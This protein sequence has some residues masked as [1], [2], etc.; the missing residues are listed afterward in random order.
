M[1]SAASSLLSRTSFIGFSDV[2]SSSTTDGGGFTGGDARVSTQLTSSPSLEGSV[3]DRTITAS[4]SR[5]YDDNISPTP[6]YTGG[7]A[8]FLVV[9]KRLGKK[10]AMTKHKAL[11]E[12]ARL[13]KSSGSELS[14]SV[15]E[16]LLP[17]WVHV[18][19]RLVL[20]EN[21]RRVREVLFSTT[22]PALFARDRKSMVRVLGPH[23]IGPWWLAM[24]DSQK[25]VANAA[26]RAFVTIFPKDLR[27]SDILIESAPVII[28][29]LHTNLRLAREEVALDMS[30]SARSS[31]DETEERLERICVCSLTALAAL[32]MALDQETLSRLAGTVST[33]EA[34]DPNPAHGGAPTAAPSLATLASGPNS[35]FV[36]GRSE[37]LTEVIKDEAMW[38]FL[39]DP[40]PF[41]RRAA[42]RLLAAV[43]GQAGSAMGHRGQADMVAQQI[44]KMLGERERG[45]FPAMWEGILVFLRHFPE[46]L[47]SA[48]DCKAQLFPRLLKLVRASFCGAAQ[49]SCPS[50]LPFVASVPPALSRAFSVDLLGSLWTGASADKHDGEEPYMVAIIE[51]ATYMLIRQPC[52]DAEEHLVANKKELE[53]S[54]GPLDGNNAGLVF[55]REILRALARVLAREARSGQ[56]QA[57]QALLTALVQFNNARMERGGRRHCLFLDFD[58]CFWRGVQVVALRVLGIDDQTSDASDYD[59]ALS[60]IPEA[61]PWQVESRSVWLS[62]LLVDCYE[63]GAS[64]GA[65]GQGRVETTLYFLFWQCVLQCQARDQYKAT[66][67]PYLSFMKPIVSL[68]PLERLFAVSPSPPYASSSSLVLYFLLP[69]LEKQMDL[70][71]VK[72]SKAVVKYLVAITTIVNSWLGEEGHWQELLGTLT[73]NVD[74]KRTGRL[75]FLSETFDSLSTTYELA[76]TSLIAHGCPENSLNLTLLV[77][78]ALVPYVREIIETDDVGKRN[79]ETVAFLASCLGVRRSGDYKAREGDKPQFDLTSEGI[80]SQLRQPQLDSS[81]IGRLVER[82]LARGSH[83][84]LEAFMLALDHHDAGRSILGAVREK[85][86]AILS[87]AFKN[88]GP[89]V[90]VRIAS[91]LSLAPREDAMEKE[92]DQD[93]GQNLHQLETYSFRRHVTKWLHSLLAQGRR[94]DHEQDWAEFFIRLA[95]ILASASLEPPSIFLPIL[96]LESGLADIYLWDSAA[97]EPVLRAHMWRYLQAVVHAL[98]EDRSLQ[99]AF[100]VKMFLARSGPLLHAI[101]SAGVVSGEN[102]TIRGPVPGRASFAASRYLSGAPVRTS[103]PSDA[104]FQLL[105]FKS[106]EDE[107][108]GDAFHS[109]SQVDIEIIQNLSRIVGKQ[110]EIIAISSSWTDAYLLSRLISVFEA[111]FTREKGTFTPVQVNERAFGRVVLPKEQTRSF[112]S[113]DDLKMGMEVW[114]RDRHMPASIADSAPDRAWMRGN[115][116][117]IHRDDIEKYFTVKKIDGGETQMEFERLRRAKPMDISGLVAGVCEGLPDLQFASA[118]SISASAMFQKTSKQLSDVCGL[119]MS[120]LTPYLECAATTCSKVVLAWSLGE[121]LRGLQAIISPLHSDAVLRSEVDVWMQKMQNKWFGIAESALEQAEKE[122]ATPESQW[123]VVTSSLYLLAGFPSLSMARASILWSALIRIGLVTHASHG[124]SKENLALSSGNGTKSRVSVIPVD[125]FEMVQVATLFWT[126]GLSKTCREQVA[127]RQALEEMWTNSTVGTCMSESPSAFLAAVDVGLQTVLETGGLDLLPATKA[128]LFRLALHGFTTTTKIKQ[129]TAQTTVMSALRY[130]ICIRCRLLAVMLI[131]FDNCDLEWTTQ[132]YEMKSSSGGLELNMTLWSTDVDTLLQILES[133]G[134]SISSSFH[135]GA[136]HL[137]RPYLR[138][139]TEMDDD[140]DDGD[141]STFADFLPLL[142]NERAKTVANDASERKDMLRD[143]RIVARRLMPRF[144]RML[145]LWVA[146]LDAELVHSQILEPH[147]TQRLACLLKWEGLLEMLGGD[148][149]EDGMPTESLN[150]YR[151]G[152]FQAIMAWLLFLEHVEAVALSPSLRDAYSTYVSL[153]DSLP[154]LLLACFRILGRRVGSSADLVS[155][156]YDLQDL[157]ATSHKLESGT[158]SSATNGH[159]IRRLVAYVVVRTIVTFPALV[160]K[161]WS[162]DS[163]RWLTSSVFKFV[164]EYASG[165]IVQREIDLIHA[166]SRGYECPWGGGEDEIAVRGSTITREV[167][168]HYLKDDCT[169][170]IL[171]RLPLAYPLRNVEVECTRS[172]GVSADKLNRWQLQI[173]TLLSMRDGSI[174]DAVALWVKNLQR[175][176]EGMGPCPICMSIIEARNLSLPERECRT[177]HNRFHNSCILKWFA[178]SGKNRCVLCQ[179]PTIG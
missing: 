93:E 63:R 137:L 135:M 143:V 27:R 33:E 103:M 119:L 166:K 7:D 164:E 154:V 156:R 179:Q 159:D 31:T 9:F 32:L 61:G 73:R 15:V 96:L 128:S 69:T 177:C 162:S 152:L 134:Y 55:V 83:V 8:D 82:T 147:P 109:E 115:I 18:Y 91:I 139:V 70:I 105:F 19:P 167:T 145:S 101:L 150:G 76:R 126:V 47:T 108:D 136:F 4:S 174:V 161:W 100:D 178:T 127:C 6:F 176:F 75:E 25:E 11:L 77:S 92:E 168:A 157:W 41:V 17:Y 46:T 98:E 38:K 160:R 129:S 22:L 123:A 106:W 23:L 44:C 3:V 122:R 48:L 24:R 13:I 64:P 132:I 12:L 1:D 50:L 10:D 5:V 39:Q 78:D 87:S 52:Q 16:G 20:L 81:A 54:I 88:I 30:D 65:T 89:S 149:G 29:Y 125:M 144:H 173:I 153:L 80:K 21:D 57:F 148:E 85:V 86:P 118:A 90:D 40:R 51:I 130:E 133:D 62:K 68:I 171:L 142:E 59:E 45:N 158:G 113:P 60:L 111:A 112:D 84:G 67:L 172:L 117:G 141:V 165:R 146:P 97:T 140:S 28:G 42:Y 94:V 79:D 34:P 170:E 107:V 110:L 49:V 121:V 155:S 35:I 138:S 14:S 2:T 58:D 56:P 74:I 36:E 66:L 163:E 43:A 116:V 114:Y 26:N 124:K 120:I 37:S 151:Q 72:G 53:R 71:D 99:A 169:L 95:E 131:P 102:K 175:E 104:P